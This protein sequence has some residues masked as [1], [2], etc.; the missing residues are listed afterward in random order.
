MH[1]SRPHN[2][3]LLLQAAGWMQMLFHVR[4]GRQIGPFRWLLAHRT[5]TGSQHASQPECAGLEG[6]SECHPQS[7]WVQMKNYDEVIDKC[8]ILDRRWVSLSH[9]VKYFTRFHTVNSQSTSKNFWQTKPNMFLSNLRDNVAPIIIPNTL[10]MCVWEDY[11]YL[12]QAFRWFLGNYSEKRLK[13]ITFCVLMDFLPVFP[14]TF[15]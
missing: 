2:C 6:P 11:S 5:D 4:L 9:P 3:Q 10:K 13:Y 14:Q 7:L 12:K 8:P 1:R 15:H